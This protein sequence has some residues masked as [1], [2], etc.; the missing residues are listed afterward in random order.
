MLPFYCAQFSVETGGVIGRYT[1][2]QL[3]VGL[4]VV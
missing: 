4:L 3:Q 2:V 1:A